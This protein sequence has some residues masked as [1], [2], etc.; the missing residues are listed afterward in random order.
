L[1]LS[2]R[3][4]PRFAFTAAPGSWAEEDPELGSKPLITDL[5]HLP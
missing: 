5:K 3:V 1:I 2:F 4:L